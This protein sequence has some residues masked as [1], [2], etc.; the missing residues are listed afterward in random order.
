[1]WV[2]ETLRLAEFNCITSYKG[3][4]PVENG[5]FCI[6]WTNFNY[7]SKCIFLGKKKV[8][9]WAIKF[10]AFRVVVGFNV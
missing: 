10:L 8:S 9:N 3:F 2:Y 1:M 5:S 7:T 4:F 6:Y